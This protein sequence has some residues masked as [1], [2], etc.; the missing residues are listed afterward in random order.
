VEKEPFGIQKVMLAITIGQCKGKTV[1]YGEMK[2]AQAVFLTKTA[3]RNLHH[4]L[5]WTIKNRLSHREKVP[6]HCL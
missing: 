1:E 5:Q 2:M 6:F 3:T 4:Q